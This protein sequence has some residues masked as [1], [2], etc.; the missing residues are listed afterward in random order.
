[1]AEKPSRTKEY[2]GEAD[3]V[4]GAAGH[5]T[6]LFLE[7]HEDL[8]PASTI[9]QIIDRES[10]RA[11]NRYLELLSWKHNTDIST[12]P[13]ITIYATPQF[14]SKLIARTQETNDPTSPYRVMQVNEQMSAIYLEYGVYVM[15]GNGCQFFQEALVTWHDSGGAVKPFQAPYSHIIRVEGN[16]EQPEYDLWQNCNYNPDGAPKPFPIP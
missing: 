14:A 13:G 9:Q 2:T 4:G 12:A 7:Q 10:Q 6:R 11:R 8:I 16:I 15:G 5:R 1:M 3:A